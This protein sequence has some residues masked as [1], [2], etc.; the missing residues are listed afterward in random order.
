MN[1]PL[2][3]LLCLGMTACAYMTYA[4]S[5]PGHKHAAAETVDPADPGMS[6]GSAER[7]LKEFLQKGVREHRFPGGQ[8][9][10]G[11]KKGPIYSTC[12]GAFD[13][14]GNH[15]VV[16][17]DLYDLAS[18]T[19]V[20]STTLAI[21]RLYGEGQVRLTDKLGTV[22]PQY[23]DTPVAELTVRELLRHTSGMFPVVY[24]CELTGKSLTDSVS[25]LRSAPDSLHPVK[26]APRIYM[27]DTFTYNRHYVSEYPD[28]ATLFAVSP[29]LW[30]YPSLIPAIDSA[31]VASFIPEQ[32][33][34]FRYS[35]LNFYFLQK[36]VEASCG[37]PLDEYV[38]RIYRDMGLTRIGYRPLE[39]SSIDHIA[40]TEYDMTMRRD[41]IRGYVHDE[42][43]ATLGGVCGNAGLFADA[44]DVAALC[45]MFLSDGTWKGQRII[46]PEVLHLFTSEQMAPGGRIT[47][48]L[49]FDKLKKH[50]Y[51]PTSYGHTGFTGTYFWCDPA[52]DLYVVFLTNGV[53]PARLRKTLGSEYRGNVWTLAKELRKAY[54]T[55]R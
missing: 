15:K 50:P 19:K 23:K 11:T 28:S 1:L 29:R 48:G 8:L 13:Y 49:G 47:R 26:V 41:T 36:I 12:V 55:G 14:D 16:D 3:Y 53:Y 21:M 54:G 39:W 25:I 31:V 24:V 40:P 7:R 22:V 44:A 2:K 9:V 51:A 18:L 5:T 10:V 43:C 37:K 4:A 27:V 42:F 6:R 45:Q 17:T 33:G 30:V 20:M 46:K 32:R 38:E 35:C 34:H 52:L